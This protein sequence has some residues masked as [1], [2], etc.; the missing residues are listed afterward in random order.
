MKNVWLVTGGAGY[1]GSH[2][3]QELLSSGNEVVVLDDLS[4]GQ[5]SFVP[6]GAVLVRGSI[7]DPKKIAKALKISR[8]KGS[9]VS[10]MHVA[11]LKLA[12]ESMN[13]PEKYWRVNVQGTLTLLSEARKFKIERIVFSSSCSVYGTTG[14]SRVNE[15]FSVNPESTYAKTKLAAEQ[16]IQDFARIKGTPTIALR[17]FNV[18]GTS[19]S[20]V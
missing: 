17:Y 4:T 8:K 13:D 19:L 12:G 14:D 18:A 9:S 11:G 5:A 10:I 7:L 3:V 2:V 6:L 20:Y 15:S 16:I 1:I